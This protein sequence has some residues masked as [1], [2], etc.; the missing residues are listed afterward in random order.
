MN[1][2]EGNPNMKWCFLYGYLRPME[3]LVFSSLFFFIRSYFLDLS[4]KTMGLYNFIIR[5]KGVFSS[6]VS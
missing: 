2:S 4:L 5:K 3:Y 1:I 6:G